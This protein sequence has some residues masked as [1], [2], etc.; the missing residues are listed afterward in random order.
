VDARYVEIRR[1]QGGEFSV[2][3]ALRYWRDVISSS[4]DPSSVAVLAIGGGAISAA[5]FRIALALG[6]RVG[7]LRGTGREAEALL[8][9]RDW[10]IS[11]RVTEL[12]MDAASITEFLRS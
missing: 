10:A 8:E 2:S 11:D 5:E 1:T 7:V 12:D 6:A 4:I 3:E 9:D